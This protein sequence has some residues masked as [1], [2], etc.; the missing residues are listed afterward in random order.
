MLNCFYE[1]FVIFI[2]FLLQCGK[3]LFDLSQD[4]LQCGFTLLAALLAALLEIKLLE[5]AVDNTLFNFDKV[6][7][8][9]LVSALNDWLEALGEHGPCENK[10]LGQFLSVAL[11]AASSH[12]EAPPLEV[13]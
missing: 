12:C 4:L 5:L 3:N 11:V 1:V 13:L 9:S 10:V 6:E 8:A 7:E 2:D